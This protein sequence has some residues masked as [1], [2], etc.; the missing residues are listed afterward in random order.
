M[1]SPEFRRLTDVSLSEIVA[2]QNHPL[3]RRTLPLAREPMTEEDA[4]G[5]VAGKERLWTE[6]GYGPWAFFLAG[7]FVGWGGLQPEVSSSGEVDADLALI[8][9]PEHWGLARQ[10]YP[11]IVR[12]A[13]EDM[14]LP[15]ITILLPIQRP[16]SGS[17]K[18]LGYVTEGELDYAGIRFIKYRLKSD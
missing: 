12:R 16:G 1:P 7:K 14:G 3:V 10:L 2:L 15:S 11:E 9:H 18:R 13:F 17:L 6:Y 8:V 4:R 5:F